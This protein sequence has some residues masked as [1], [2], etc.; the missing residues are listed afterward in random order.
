[1]E[2]AVEGRDGVDVD[3]TGVVVL[4]GEDMLVD[5]EADFRWKHGEK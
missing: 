2:G 4:L 1:M 3:G 5:C